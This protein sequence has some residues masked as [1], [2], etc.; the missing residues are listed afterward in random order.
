M[1]ANQRVERTER[2]FPVGLGVHRDD[3]ATLA[4]EQLMT[5][6]AVDSNAAESEQPIE[7]PPETVDK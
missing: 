5:S 4:L 2:H 1:I 7:P 3:D 6:P